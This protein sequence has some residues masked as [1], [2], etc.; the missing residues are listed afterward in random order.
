VI[1]ELLE[2]VWHKGVIGT[3][4]E[5]F[6]DGFYGVEFDGPDGVPLGGVDFIVI[7]ESELSRTREDAHG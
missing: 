2:V 1:F 7:H 6:N 3:I 4:I 5:I